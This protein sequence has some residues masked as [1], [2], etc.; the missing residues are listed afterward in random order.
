MERT[1]DSVHGIENSVD[2]MWKIIKGLSDH[3][4]RIDTI[5]EVIDDIT[6][7]VHVLSLNASIEATKAGKSGEGFMVIAKQIRSLA[8]N[9]KD[10]TEEILSIINTFQKDIN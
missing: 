2:E 3:S 10:S 8:E 6:S 4:E 9:T 5:L 7:R 1:F